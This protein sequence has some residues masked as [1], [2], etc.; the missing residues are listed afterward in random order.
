M[1]DK[2]FGQHLEDGLTSLG[3]SLT[4]RSENQKKWNDESRSLG[5][6]STADKLRWLEAEAYRKTRVNKDITQELALIESLR[7]TRKMENRQADRNGEATANGFRFLYSIGAA[8][9]FTWAGIVAIVEPTNKVCIQNNLKSDYCEQVRNI[10]EYFT[11][12]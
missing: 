3:N 4:E 6:I 1:S 12:K 10:G 2:S 5:L 8:C 11:G 7:E 9:F